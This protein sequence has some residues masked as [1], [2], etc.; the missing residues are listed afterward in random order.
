M[1]DDIQ[2]LYIK[3]LKAQLLENTHEA[4]QRLIARYPY[5]FDL[6]SLIP[7]PANPSDNDKNNSFL[8]LYQTTLEEYRD[9]DIEFDIHWVNNI[10]SRFNY[11]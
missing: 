4:I 2:Q 7:P 5:E 8:E 3:Q 10:V 6:H 9:N 11:P 1:E